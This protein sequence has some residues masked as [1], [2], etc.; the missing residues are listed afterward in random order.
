MVLEFTIGL[1]IAFVVV[2]AGSYLGSKMALNTFF[3]RDFDPSETGQFATRNPT[4]D[5]KDR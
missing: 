1:A 2:V 3:G 4:S 5:D